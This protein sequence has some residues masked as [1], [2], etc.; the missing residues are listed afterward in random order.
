MDQLKENSTP[1]LHEYVKFTIRKK[2]AY[3][4]KTEIVLITQ[5][6]KNRVE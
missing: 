6:K 2:N 1:I 4:S 3:L 5:K